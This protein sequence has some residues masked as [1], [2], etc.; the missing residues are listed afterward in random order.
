MSSVLYFNRDLDV[1]EVP[2]AAHINKG[3]YDK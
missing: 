1:E 3:P 2:K